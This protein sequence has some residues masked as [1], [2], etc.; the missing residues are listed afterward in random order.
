MRKGVGGG[1]GS[2]GV[3]R[4]ATMCGIKVKLLSR[5]FFLFFFFFKVRNEA[6]KFLNKTAKMMREK[7]RKWSSGSWRESKESQRREHMSHF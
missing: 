3:G 4:L 6:T 2:G 1:V 7:W 5:L